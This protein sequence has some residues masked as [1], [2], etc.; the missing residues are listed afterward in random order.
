VERALSVF[1]FFKRAICLRI[2]F[3][4]VYRI[5]IVCAQRCRVRWFCKYTLCEENA[6]QS[7]FI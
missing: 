6:I 2:V 7:P 1:L 4:I 3:V 5:R